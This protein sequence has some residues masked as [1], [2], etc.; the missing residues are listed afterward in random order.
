MKKKRFCSL[1]L[2]STL[3]LLDKI[4]R[5]LVLFKFF[6]DIFHKNVLSSSFSSS[7]LIQKYFKHEITLIPLISSR[8]N[9]FLL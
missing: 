1:F 3:C 4:F 6:F 9:F 5:L 2:V 7:S 8:T